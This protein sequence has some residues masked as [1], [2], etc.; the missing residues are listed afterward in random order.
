M[1]HIYEGSIDTVILD[2][3]AIDLRIQEYQEE[4]E[5]LKAETKVALVNLM[6]LIE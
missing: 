1:P 6:L 4:I 5:S 3:H 2:L